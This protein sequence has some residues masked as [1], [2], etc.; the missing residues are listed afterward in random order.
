M[1][2]P[3]ASQGGAWFGTWEDFHG[4]GTRQAAKLGAA[5]EPSET[6]EPATAAPVLSRLHFITLQQ[7]TSD[8]VASCLQ[9]VYQSCFINESLRLCSGLHLCLLALFHRLESTRAGIQQHLKL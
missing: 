1:R 7:V 3:R 2:V 9:R 8:Q 5:R 4:E 6:S